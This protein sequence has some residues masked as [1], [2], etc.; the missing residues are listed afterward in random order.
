MRTEQTVT[1][2]NGTWREVL[3]DGRPIGVR[4]QVTESPAYTAAEAPA[5][6]AAATARTTKQT[7][8]D[9]ATTILLTQVARVRAI[10]AGSR[11]DQDRWLMALSWLVLSQE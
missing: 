9:A 6:T 8:D 7:K 5:R 3:E 1:D 11:S 10:P 2:A 4:Y